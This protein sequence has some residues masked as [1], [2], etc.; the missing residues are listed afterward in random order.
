MYFGHIPLYNVWNSNHY[1]ILDFPPSI[2]TRRLIPLFPRPVDHHRKLLI[3][4]VH[5]VSSVLIPVAR[6]LWRKFETTETFK[7]LTA[8]FIFNALIKYIESAANG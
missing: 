2:Q 4:Y 1:L 3:Y 7:V 5:S 6:F 8:I